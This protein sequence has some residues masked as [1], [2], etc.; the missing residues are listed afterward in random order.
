MKIGQKQKKNY[1]NTDFR[2]IPEDKFTK[3]LDY[4]CRV[5]L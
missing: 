4:L 5:K 2:P 1:G 3:F